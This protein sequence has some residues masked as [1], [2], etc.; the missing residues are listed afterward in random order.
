MKQIRESYRVIKKKYAKI[1]K[2]TVRLTQSSLI[3]MQA[4]DPA[5]D[6]YK[7][8]V[9]ETD[10]ATAPFPDEI[11]LNINDEFISYD[12]AYYLV[13]EKTWNHTE[14]GLTSS[15][16][17]GN[18]YFTHAPDELNGQFSLLEKA[19]DGFLQILVN[20]ISRLEKWDLKKHNYIPRTQFQ[21]SSAGIPSATQPSVDYSDHGTFPMQPMLTLSGAKKNDILVTLLGGAIPSTSTGNWVLPSAGDTI[22]F[23][24]NRLALFFRGM[25]AQN[26]AKFQ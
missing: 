12:V 8:P 11:R 17:A 24:I 26:A 13:A 15:V 3:L 23:K 2:G 6:V 16:K 5:K 25:L 19:W 10:T 4:I 20:K 22:D 18:F 14:G 1:G 21:N 7:F 9:L